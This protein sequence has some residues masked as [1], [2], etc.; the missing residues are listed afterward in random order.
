MCNPFIL[1]PKNLTQAKAD[2]VGRQHIWHEWIISFSTC[3]FLFLGL[4]S[5]RMKKQWYMLSAQV[6]LEILDAQH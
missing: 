2:V 5:G 6:P 3:N 4:V 1:K